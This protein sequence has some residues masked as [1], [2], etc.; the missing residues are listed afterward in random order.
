MSSQ[1]N[2]AFPLHTVFYSIGFKIVSISF[3]R[4]RHLCHMSLFIVTR[5]QGRSSFL[6]Y[7]FSWFYSVLGK[8][9]AFV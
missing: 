9:N 5:K 8:L 1:V 6:N 2:Y 3:F 4:A 7:C